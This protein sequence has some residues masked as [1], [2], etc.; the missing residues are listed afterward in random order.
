[1]SI[2]TKTQFG[3]HTYEFHLNADGTYNIL[4]KNL[5][6]NSVVLFEENL[7]K[8]LAHLAFKCLSK[9]EPIQRSV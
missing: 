6:N 7:H 4:K 9:G 8:L 3:N 5:I 2:V 1:M